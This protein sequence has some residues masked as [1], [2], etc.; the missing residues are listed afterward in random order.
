[1]LTAACGANEGVL[2]S[3]RET[4]TQSNVQ[5]AKTTME[6]DIDEMRTAGFS[7][8]YVLRRKDGQKFDSEDRGVVRLQTADANRRVTS[9]EDRAV[10]IGTNY[11]IPPQNM[12]ILFERFAVENYSPPATPADTNTAANGAR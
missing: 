1:M 8:I 11:A 7:F 12:M 5:S 4:P 9:D 6:K 2:R 10:V 3:G